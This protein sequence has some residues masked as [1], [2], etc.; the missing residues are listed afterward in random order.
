MRDVNW[1]DSVKEHVSVAD[2]T[3]HHQSFLLTNCMDQSISREAN[4]F[5]ASQEFP[6]TLWKPKVYYNIQNFPHP[7]PIQS[8]FIQV[9]DPR[10]TSW[11]NSKIILLSHKCLDLPSGLFP[12]QF[13][14]RTLYTS[15][16]SPIIFMNLP[17]FYSLFD[18]PNNI[19]WYIEPTWSR[20]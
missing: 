10:S 6:R 2:V 16:L 12:L 5:S 11:I 7:D 15:L 3:W 18:H 4:R 20:P 1:N 14:T 19:W 13:L 17:I 9:H 8:H